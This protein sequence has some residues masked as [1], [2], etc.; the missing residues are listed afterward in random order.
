MERAPGVLQP[1][2]VV[3]AALDALDADESVVVP[4][5]V[6]RISLALTR[7]LPV[8][9]ASR[10]AGSAMERMRRAAARG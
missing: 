3:R 2:A 5:L 10:L 7:V 1:D 6:N 8:P 9:L 4:G